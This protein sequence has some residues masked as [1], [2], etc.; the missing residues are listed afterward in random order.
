MKTCVVEM[1]Y[2]YNHCLLRECSKPLMTIIIINISLIPPPI[3]LV[4]F[5]K[6]IRIHLKKWLCCCCLKTQTLELRSFSGA[7]ERSTCTTRNYTPSHP[8][9]W[10]SLLLYCTHAVL[11]SS[12]VLTSFIRI[13]H[14]ILFHTIFY[15]NTC[16]QHFCKVLTWNK[17]EREIG[18]RYLWRP[19]LNSNMIK[20]GIDTNKWLMPSVSVSY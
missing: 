9:A 20:F 10:V 13:I 12:A 14:C 7:R 3:L 15:M 4:I 2:N 5:F 11:T 16:I 8:T 19:F 18:L 1:L 17:W 6:S